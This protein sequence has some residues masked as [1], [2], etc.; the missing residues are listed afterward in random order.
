MPVFIRFQSEQNLLSLWRCLVPTLL[1][2]TA[3]SVQAQPKDNSTAVAAALSE[4]NACKQKVLEFER[5]IGLIRQ[6]QGEKAAAELKEHLLPQKV[7]SE[8]LFKD[9]YCGLARYIR[10]KKLDR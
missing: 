5:A 3:A 2:L 1:I 9:G 4:P 7:E 10:E 6:L 8:I